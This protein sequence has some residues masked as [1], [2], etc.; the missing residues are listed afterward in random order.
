MAGDREERKR[1]ILIIVPASLRKQWHQELSDKFFLPSVI[2]ETKTFNEQ[3]RAGNL[4]P[5]D[6]SEIVICS[7]QFARSK[8]VYLPQ[9]VWN[10]AVIDEAPRPAR[11]QARTTQFSRFWEA[12]AVTEPC[13]RPQLTKTSA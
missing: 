7:Y 10:L 4:N 1:K 12:A 3:I 11:R 8:E 6:R 5:F 9:V 2:L 13:C